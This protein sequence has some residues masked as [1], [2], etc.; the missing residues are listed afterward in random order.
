MP[1]RVARFETIG[2]QG[3]LVPQVIGRECKWPDVL[4][5]IALVIAVSNVTVS[6]GIAIHSASEGVCVGYADI[7]LSTTLALAFLLKIPYVWHHTLPSITMVTLC[8]GFTILSAVHI[9]CVCVNPHDT[10]I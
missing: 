7:M 10:W 1:G 9:V 3:R 4:Y 8:L 6:I 5:V 2:G